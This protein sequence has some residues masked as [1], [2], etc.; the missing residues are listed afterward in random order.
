MDGF[1]ALHV[2]L[3]FGHSLQGGQALL[4]LLWDGGLYFAER[5]LLGF[6]FVVKGFETHFS[7]LAHVRRLLCETVGLFYSNQWRGKLVYRIL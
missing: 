3:H 2:L 6:I 4:G 7:F 1:V 5:G